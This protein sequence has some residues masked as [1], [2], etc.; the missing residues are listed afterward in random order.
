MRI[1]VSELAHEAQLKGMDDNDKIVV[2][3]TARSRTGLDRLYKLSWALDRRPEF[4][5]APVVQYSRRLQV[6]LLPGQYPRASE[7]LCANW[8]SAG[9]ALVHL[10]QE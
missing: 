6:T 10:G 5:Y 4:S 3:A 1:Y 2:F 9:N 7:R 8:H